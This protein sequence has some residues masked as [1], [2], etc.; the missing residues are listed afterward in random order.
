MLVQFCT[1]TG[2]APHLKILAEDLDPDISRYVHDW[3]NYELNNVF[4]TQ[5]KTI[6]SILKWGI[7]AKSRHSAKQS[8][9]VI[10]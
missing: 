2:F 7:Q 1:F 10:L 8:H 9:S 6:Q 4:L 5:R 3:I